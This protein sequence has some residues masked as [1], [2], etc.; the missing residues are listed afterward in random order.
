ME[1]PAALRARLGYPPERPCATVGG[2]R[3]RGAQLSCTLQGFGDFRWADAAGLAR[4]DFTAQVPVELLL[5]VM[6]RDARRMRGDRPFL[7]A[8]LR[9]GVGVAEIVAQL[10][11]LGGLAPAAAAG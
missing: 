9:H 11:A 8:S 6:E 1:E 7:F 10:R 2:E 5:E 3:I 4:A